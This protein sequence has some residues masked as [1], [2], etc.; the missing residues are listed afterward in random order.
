MSGWALCLVLI[1]ATITMAASRPNVILVMTDDQGFGEV[2]FHGNPVLKTPNLDRF[3]AEGTELVN[4]YVSPMCTPTRSSLMT[5]R[6]H[7]RTGAHDTYIGRSNMNP[8]ETT[9]AEVFAGVGYRTGI[10]GKWHLG[11]NYPMRA[12]DQGFQKVV[13]H[14]GGG[15]GQFAD[16]PGNTYWSP[17]LL[18]NDE[19]K[20]AEGYCTDVFID[21]SIQFIRDSGDTPFFCY[22]PL[23]V[24]HSPFDVAKEFREPYDQQKLAD[25]DGR[26]WVAPIYGMITQMDV[27]F[28]R[29]LDAVEDMGLRENTIVIFMTDNGPNSTYFTAGLRARKGSVYENGIRSPFVIQWPKG[30]KGGRKISDPAMHIDLLPTLAEACG[31]ALPAGMEIDGTSILGRLTGEVE[32][33]PE[34][35]LFMQHNRG[36]LPTRYKNGMVRKGPWKMVAPSGKP[37]D[38]ALYNLDEDPGEK[39]NLAAKHPDK[40]AEFVQEYD[41]WF[42]DVTEELRRVEGMPHPI[43]LDPVQKQDFRFTWQ[44]WWGEK[45]GWRH[46][47]YG[48]WRMSNPGK[49][50][51]FDVTIGVPRPHRGK[52]ASLKFV[53]QGK[54]VEK[55]IKELPAQVVLENIKLAKGTG[56]MEAQLHLGGKMWG[57]QEVQIKPHAPTDGAAVP[58]AENLPAK[59][60]FVRVEIPGRGRV[61]SLAEVEIFEKGVNIARKKQARQSTVGFGGEPRR[62]V[63][64]N[65]DGDYRNHSVTHTEHG[66]ADPWWEVDLGRMAAIEGIALHNRTDSNGERLQGF[67]LKVL[68]A[69]R[70]VVFS[71]QNNRQAPMMPFGN[72]PTEKSPGLLPNPAFPGERRDFRGFD[73]Y[74]FRTE[75][76]VPIQVIC[77]KEAAPGKPW[78]WRSLFWDAIKRFNEA[79]MKLVEEGYHIVLVHG[80]VA[81]HPSGNA[82]IDAAYDLLTTEHGFSNKCSMASMS[83]GT[84]SLFRWASTHPEKVESVYVD[85]GVCN[86]LSWPAGKLVPGN[87]SI[88]SGAPSSWA[89]F[90]KRFGYQTDAEALKTKESPIDQLEPLARAGVPILMVCGSKDKAVPYEEN[91]AIMEQRYKALGGDIT[92]IVEDKGHSHGMQDPTPVLEFIRRHT[93]TP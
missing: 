43:E 82:N 14:G 69:Q 23:N 45:T 10:F 66:G 20:G 83:R 61:L 27:A 64:G 70:G 40:V 22:I 11:E 47:N 24:P 7:F 59:G 67:T 29:L 44:D 36:N 62:A 60:Q 57:A 84:L 21:E 77:P 53:W 79:D 51:R 86:V 38:A 3:A 49:I 35:T 93:A 65:T 31:I 58:T 13:V 26:N 55:K 46:T 34:R 33:L 91:D 48:A 16:V 28:Q 17:T 68:D 19:F 41:A 15:I 18:Y 2:G 72:C 5:G 30:M 32:A 90:K 75:G 76:G 9:I 56:F 71:R 88:A 39:T 37:G 8:Q 50:E 52:P 80:D 92:V 63:D 87:D 78:L 12:Q 85:N 25:P 54:T 42:D 89:D 6:Y 81:G 1:S 73:R 4:F 74:K